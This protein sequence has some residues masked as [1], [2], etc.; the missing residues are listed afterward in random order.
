MKVFNSLIYFQVFIVLKKKNSQLTFLHCYHH[1]GMFLGSY[2]AAKWVCGGSLAI[3]GVVNAFVHSIMYFY[4][5][6]TAFKPE[7]KK[8]L[9]WKKHITQ[10]QLAQFAILTFA[11]LSSAFAENCGFPKVVSWC[12]VIQNTFMLTLFGDFYVKAYHKGN[13]N[14]M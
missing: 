12:L 7:L 2:C 5:W 6:I 1:S 3:L 9:W 10:V 13:K 8:S 11:Y 14:E 4:Y